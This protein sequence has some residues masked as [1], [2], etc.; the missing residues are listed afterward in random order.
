MSVIENST[1]ANRPICRC[2][3]NMWLS[4]SKQGKEGIECI[5][6]CPVCDAGEKAII[7]S[8]PPDASENFLA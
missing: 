8:P 7:T 4:E 1:L 3:M 6:L 5:F 2:G